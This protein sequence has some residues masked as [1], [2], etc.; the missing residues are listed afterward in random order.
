MPLKIL[1]RYILRKFLGTFV[2][3][4]AL[5][6]MISVVVDFSEKVDDLVESK[7]SAWQIITGF[8]LHFLPFITSLIGPFFV[9]VACMFFTS[10]L[11]ARS[12]IIAILNSGTSFYR[13]LYPYFLGA[14]ILAAAFY[15]GNHYLVPKS[16][17]KR[18]DFEEKYIYKSRQGLRF[19]F[20]RTI[21]P[22][23]IIYMENYSP[24]QAHGYRFSID[25]FEGN[26]LVYKLMADKIEWD[27]T[28]QKWRLTNVFIRKIKPGKDEIIRA[29]TADSAFTYRP[30]NFQLARHIKEE[31][32]TPELI[33]YIREMYASG[34]QDIEFYEVE[35]YRRSSSAISIYILTLIG[36]SIASRKMRGGLGWH[37]VLGIGLSALYEVIMKFSV[38]FSTNS[39]LP[40]VIGVWLPNMI[41]AVLALYLLKKA[42]K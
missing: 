23:H 41:F 16:N 37:L 8:Y 29:A 9:L 35:R 38:T 32:P 14:T 33:K 11:A 7:L 40:P 34:Q 12:E 10:Q 21:S 30:E 31:M 6:L 22:G 36:V 24:A 4:M 1:D 17:S 42:P 27:S 25:R 13:M 2:F 19:N 39:T 28:K 3:I 18:L 26:R 15:V 5:L 20:H